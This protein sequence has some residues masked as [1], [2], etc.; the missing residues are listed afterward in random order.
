MESKDGELLGNVAECYS[1]LIGRPTSCGGPTGCSRPIS[2]SRPADCGGSVC[3]IRPISCGGPV[4]YIRSVACGR[5]VPSTR[6]I[7]SVLDEIG[8]FRRGDFQIGSS[9]AI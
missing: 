1:E 5:P 4:G 7:P 2:C 9:R 6:P 8:I 3:C